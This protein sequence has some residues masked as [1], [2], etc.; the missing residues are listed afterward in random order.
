[1][2]ELDRP[3]RARK[4]AL[5][6]EALRRYEIRSLADL[7][8]CW[9][10]NGAHT[11]EAMA[12]GTLD[13]AVIVDGHITALTRQRAEGRT[14]L[15]LVEAPL[16]VETTV[17]AV[18]GVDA[19]IMFDI[20]LHQ[21]APDWDEF[22]ARYA[23]RVDTLIIY[24]QGWLG[25][26][27]IRF[28]D[29]TLE[30]YLDRVFHADAARIRQWYAKHGELNAEQGKPWRDAHNFWQWG[31]TQADLVGC[32]WRLGY[33]VDLLRNDGVFNRRF[34]EIEALGLIA[35]KRHLAA[36]ATGAPSAPVRPKQTRTAAAPAPAHPAA[37]TP[38]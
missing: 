21:V 5:V 1:M 38:R 23:P 32:L 27:T 10:V 24:N 9:G 15:E 34:P 7:G 17:E 22:L 14:E 2:T 16:G 30:E 35:R 8:G 3:A 37:T 28:P 25:P 31:I 6:T 33:R 29:F 12:A 18:G 4:V 20:L 36:T 13:R 19:A 26:A 11:F